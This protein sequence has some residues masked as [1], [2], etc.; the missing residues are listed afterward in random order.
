MQ[1]K[2]ELTSCRYILNFKNKKWSKGMKNQK[3]IKYCPICEKEL[4][5][6]DDMNYFTSICPKCY[7]TVFEELNGKVHVIKNG[8]A[9]D[10]YNISLDIFYKQ[11]LAHQMLLKGMLG[12]VNPGEIL[13]M[14]MF[15]L[16]I[17]NESIF[18]HFINMI[19]KFKMRKPYIYFD[20]YEKY[21]EMSDKYTRENFPWFFN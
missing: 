9:K 2:Q 15:R 11:F 4:I 13:C 18:N 12:D 21:L 19:E 3:T 20:G 16:N 8:I 6:I 5:D 10:K 14:R 1:R 7:S 17:Y